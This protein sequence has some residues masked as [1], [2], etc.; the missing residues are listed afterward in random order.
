MNTQTNSQTDRQT[1]KVYILPYSMICCCIV[2]NSVILFPSQRDCIHFALTAKPGQTYMPRNRKSIQY[3]VWQL[4]TSKPFDI[5]I[6]VLISLNTVVLMM[7]VGFRIGAQC[8]RLNPKANV[9][10]ERGPA[11]VILV[12]LP[13]L[14]SAR[15]HTETND[16]A[17]V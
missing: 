6:M 1:S 14:F 4:V 13:V 5:F 3:K 12:G 16:F 15:I 2:K 9:E 8:A 7:Q 17:K 10:V 11:H